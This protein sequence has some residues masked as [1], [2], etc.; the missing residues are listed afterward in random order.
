MFA[1]KARTWTEQLQTY[2]EP[3]NVTNATKSAWI[4]LGQ[5]VYRTSTP[6]SE[7]PY[8]IIG[9]APKYLNFI[10]LN[11]DIESYHLNINTYIL[12]INN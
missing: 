9:L 7:L 3:L 12:N 6:Q 10:I 5:L 1:A 11:L 4:D 2:T 8:T